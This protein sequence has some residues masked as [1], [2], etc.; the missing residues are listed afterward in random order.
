MLMKLSSRC[1]LLLHLLTPGGKLATVMA[2]SIGDLLER[3][4]TSEPVRRRFLHDRR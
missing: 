4:A 3:G 2:G 1:S